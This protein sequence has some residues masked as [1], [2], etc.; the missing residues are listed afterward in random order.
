MCFLIQQ[1]PHP[2]DLKQQWP[3]GE[4]NPPVSP[5]P[6][7]ALPDATVPSHPRD[8]GKDLEGDRRGEDPCDLAQMERLVVNSLIQTI[9]WSHY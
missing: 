4:K 9:M 3:T 7:L 6:E 2:C 8:G 5:W 1:P